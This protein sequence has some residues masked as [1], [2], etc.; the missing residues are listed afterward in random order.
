MTNPN[1]KFVLYVY[2]DYRKEVEIQLLKIFNTKEEAIA[3]FKAN[4][5]R[6]AQEKEYDEESGEKDGDPAEY[7][8]ARDTVFDG[9]G[10]AFRDFFGSR[11]AI[12][13][14]EMA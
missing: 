6:T 2:A 7:V 14:V 10:K 13:E 5:T 8:C 4:Y 1:T 3:H 9:R 11:Y 12:Q